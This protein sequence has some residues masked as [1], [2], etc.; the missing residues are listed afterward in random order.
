MA[1]EGGGYRVGRGLAATSRPVGFAV[2]TATYLLAGVVALGVVAAVRGPH[3]LFVTLWADLAATVAVFAVS[4]VVGN[5][6]LYDPYWSVAP[7]VIAVAWVLAS[8]GGVGAR[9]AAVVV[10][11]LGWAVRLTAN[12]ALTWRGLRHEDWRYVQMRDGLHRGVPWWLVSL[13]GIQAMPTLVVFIGMLPLWPAVTASGRSFGF[14]DAVAVVVTTAAITTEATADRQLHRFAA[15]PANRGRIIDRGLWRFSRHPNYLGEIGFWC[16]MWLF[17]FAAAPG[18]WWWT[19]AGPLAMVLLFTLVSVP[20]MDRR[21]LERRPAY[22]EHMRR[23]P[24]IIPRLFTA[25][26]SPAPRA[27]PETTDEE[28]RDG[29]RQSNV[30]E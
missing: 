26:S 24:A 12:W 22:A 10:L 21:S 11:M 18:W 23:V 4:M 30:A 28:G 15:D 20:M 14:L 13:I 25:R 17:G 6:S 16:G 2:V 8:E 19:V 7:P 27:S 1:I 5:A 3:Q 29:Q 9:Q